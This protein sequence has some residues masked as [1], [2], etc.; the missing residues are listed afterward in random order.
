MLSLLI[1]REW[2]GHLRSF[3]F[4]AASILCFASVLGSIVLSAL[5]YDAARVE[6]SA[7][8]ARHHQ[9]VLSYYAWTP[10]MWGGVRVD[11][12]LNPMSLFT[13]DPDRGHLTVASVNA[14][15]EP[16][17]IDAG[18]QNPLSRLTAT[19]DLEFVIVAVLSLLA[20]VFSYDAVC[21][22]REQ[23]T[24]RLALSYPVSRGHFL[25]GKW[26]GGFLAL[27]APYLTALIGGGLVLSLGFDFGLDRTA[28]TGLAL[29]ITA[30]LLY[31]FAIFGLGVCV[32]IFVGRS[33]TSIVLLLLIWSMAVIVVPSLAPYA[34]ARFSPVPSPGQIE[35]QKQANRRDIETRTLRARDRKP[36][37]AFDSWLLWAAWSNRVRR[38]Q[39][40]EQMDMAESINERFRHD[41]ARQVD[42]AKNFS[43]ISP[44]ASFRLI[45]ASL[46][47][48]GPRETERFWQA[49][50]EYRRELC[51]F[52]YDSWAEM[53]T[54]N[55]KRRLAGLEVQSTYH[56]ERY[57]R[58]DY[59]YVG[60]GERLE[61]ALDDVLLLCLWCALFL[62]AG[63]AVFSRGDIT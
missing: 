33:V 32:S 54:D 19:V 49:L 47:A 16:T 3:R 8:V 50:V 34:A 42:L 21:G 29:L 11:K 58:F 41:M 60:L 57:P 22:E 38:D 46:S 28:W 40:L 59:Q 53:A 52:A 7:L 25:I 6:R 30:S 43:R 36:P 14:Y 12:P 17:F 20:I 23:G 55:H 27:A 62:V 45:A 9:E 35:K 1:R 44:A 31:L 26:V 13:R 5:S 39:F 2:L 18:L 15:W 61:E 4:A 48:T 63:Y 56:I 37:S 51:R 10:L 24:L